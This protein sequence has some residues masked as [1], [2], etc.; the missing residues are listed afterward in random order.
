MYFILFTYI[1]IFAVTKEQA[2]INQRL[3]HRAP[4]TASAD[5]CAESLSDD[6][7]NSF[8]HTTQTVKPSDRKE[9]QHIK[10]P[11]FPLNASVEFT[12]ATLTLN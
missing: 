12:T 6:G 1:L 10:R 4:E 7:S 2:E 9:S 3:Y 8:C 11:F 5:M